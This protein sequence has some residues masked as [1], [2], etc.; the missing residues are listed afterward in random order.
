MA[1]Q[2]RSFLSKVHWLAGD[3]DL[4]VD[5]HLSCTPRLA[6]SKPAPPATPTWHMMM[7]IMIAMLVQMQ[8]TQVQMHASLVDVQATLVDVQATSGQLL[9]SQARLEQL[10]R[11]TRTTAWRASAIAMPRHSTSSSPVAKSALL[12][13]CIVCGC[14]SEQRSFTCNAGYQQPHSRAG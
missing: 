14:Q 12:S 4:A 1:H 11:K 5:L 13:L 10:H 8:A 6:E 9:A 3:K 7:P 2:P